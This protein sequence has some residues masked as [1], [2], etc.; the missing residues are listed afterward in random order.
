LRG[1][2][3]RTILSISGPSAPSDTWVRSYVLERKSAR[4]GSEEAD[5]QRYDDHCRRDENEHADAARAIEHRGNDVAGKDSGKP[6]EGINETPRARIGV[7]NNSLWY[8]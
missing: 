7:G 1:T 4:P 8:V 3:Y 5:G 6:A 2:G